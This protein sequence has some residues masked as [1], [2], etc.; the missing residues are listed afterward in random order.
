MPFKEKSESLSCS[1][2]EVILWRDKLP[3]PISTPDVVYADGSLKSQTAVLLP[4]PRS[5]TD[6]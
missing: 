4:F 3:V 2:K 6:G 1:H 5:P